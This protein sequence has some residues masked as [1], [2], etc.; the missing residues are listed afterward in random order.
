MYLRQLIVK[1]EIWHLCISQITIFSNNDISPQNSLENNPIIPNLARIYM[2]SFYFS[3]HFSW[4]INYSKNKVT[5]NLNY[6]CTLFENNVE[7]VGL[8]MM[9]RL[10]CTTWTIWFLHGPGIFQQHTCLPM[11]P[12]M[13][14]TCESEHQSSFHLWDSGHMATHAGPPSDHCPPN[15]NNFQSKHTPNMHPEPP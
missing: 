5:T 9:V 8:S 15:N 11:W 6:L 4:T 3:A 7:T 14:K 12:L 13:H 2:E 10:P 1:L